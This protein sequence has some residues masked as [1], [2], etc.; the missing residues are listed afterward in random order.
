MSFGNPDCTCTEEA[1][2]SKECRQAW[3][4]FVDRLAESLSGKL[5]KATAERLS[6]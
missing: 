4:D 2:C 5:A 1:W 6:R 3:N